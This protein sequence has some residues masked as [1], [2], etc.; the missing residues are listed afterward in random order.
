MTAGFLRGLFEAGM[1]AGI[2][3]LVAAALRAALQHRADRRVFC[4][5]WDMCVLRLLVPVE[6]RSPLSIWRLWPADVALA[7]PSHAVAG[8]TAA[9][10]SVAPQTVAA[11]QALGEVPRPHGM[12]FA[13]WLWILW[14]AGAAVIAL[15]LVLAHVLS[16]RIYAQSLPCR[17]EYVAD[18]LGVRPLRRLVRVRVCDRIASPLTYGVLRPVI[19][20]PASMDWTDTASMRCV[21]EHE[22]EH[23][24]RFDTLR[25]AILCVVLCVYWFNPLV[26]LL[27]ALASRDM[28]LACDE[29]VVH[30]GED[31]ESYALALLGLEERRQVWSLAGSHFSM[32][33]LEE[34]IRTIMKKKKMSI[35]A[36]VAVVAVMLVATFAVAAA[37][38]DEVEAVPRGS[39]ET[40]TSLTVTD[41][42][43]D[44]AVASGDVLVREGEN[45]EMTISTD[46]GKTWK[47]MDAS[48]GGETTYVEWWTAEEYEKWL[49]QEKKNLEDV[50]G[51]R[52]YTSADGWFTWDR[53]KVDETIAMYEKILEEIRNGAKYSRLTFTSDGDEVTGE[54]ILA[55]GASEDM[56]WSVTDS[57]GGNAISVTAVDNTDLFPS[58]EP[59]GLKMDDDGNLTLDGQKVR[60]FV[61]GVDLG[62]GAITTQCAYLD[63]EGVVDAH[64]LYEATQNADGSS[65]PMGRLA[66]IAKTGDPKFSQALI[67]SVQLAA[68]QA[69][70]T[71]A[72]QEGGADMGSFILSD[73]SIQQEAL[74]DESGD[75]AE[76]RTLASVLAPYRQYGLYYDEADG[77]M[78]YRGQAVS[79]FADENP[80]GGV[81]TYT[82]DAVPDG[83]AIRTQ[84]DG[85]GHLTGLEAK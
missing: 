84:Y 59:Y 43:D 36:I 1:S 26:W 17:D 6:I 37:A 19:L 68:D 28:E 15:R 16:R 75:V 25:K 72:A 18:W 56:V 29:A 2:M 65:D 62:D 46:G 32:N 58:L 45:G 49:E 73:A 66:G 33:A 51:E 74:A 5:A 61:D 70:Q 21:L 14:M 64:T 48:E 35:M 57:E 60:T 83:L 12:A 53:Q 11:G 81:F 20:L 77:S 80:D 67:D 9:V 63:S 3:V 79:S 31:R 38:P 52:A 40:S 82:D 7:F 30:L 42:S 39:V 54:A 41:G 78:T 55:S 22:F 71:A 24:R 27:W 50:I 13:E 34:R 69:E 47:E 85:E 8:G 76:G 23:I 44:G 4:L 10:T